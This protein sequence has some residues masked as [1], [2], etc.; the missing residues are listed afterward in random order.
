MDCFH[1]KN[2]KIS[3]LNFLWFSR[4]LYSQKS[5]GKKKKNKNQGMSEFP[6]TK[7][8][9][10]VHTWPLLPPWFFKSQA[11]SRLGWT[12]IMK[13]ITCP[14][15]TNY[16]NSRKK[17]H[18]FEKNSKAIEVHDKISRAEDEWKGDF[19]KPPLYTEK[20]T[21]LFFSIF[22]IITKYDIFQV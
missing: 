17:D 3:R 11:L 22:F 4:K 15:R 2:R 16:K 8:L 14:W 5:I 13:Q 21:D 6:R 10:Y 18:R 1:W 12:W 20:W 19:W 9:D 7:K